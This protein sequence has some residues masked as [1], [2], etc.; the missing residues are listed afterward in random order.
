MAHGV[1]PIWVG[2][3]LLNPLRRILENPR[4]ILGPWVAPGMT[5]LEPGCGMGYF[6]LPL[7]RMAGQ[8]GKVVAVDIQDKMLQKVRSRAEKAGLAQRIETRLASP[9]SLQ[10]DGLQG[11]V[12]L[13]TAIHVVHEAPDP[14]G[15]FR[16][17]FEALKPGGRLL[18]IEPKGHVSREEFSGAL[19]LAA[20]CGF[21]PDPGAE[22][23][24]LN[25]AILLKA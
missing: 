13:A 16:Q 17:I 2:Y 10:L 20:C 21:R 1:C 9:D 24:A 25:Q 7:A 6:S 4:K 14:K 23:A 18:V 15:F 19:E 22:A 5:V 11:R 8:K 12:D 3:L